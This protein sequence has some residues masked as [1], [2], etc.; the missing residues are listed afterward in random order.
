MEE[1]IPSFA[2]AKKKYGRVHHI[3][4]STILLMNEQNQAHI[5]NGP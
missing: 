5:D 1:C 4:L 3:V 2:A